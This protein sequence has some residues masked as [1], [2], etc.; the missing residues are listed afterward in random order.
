MIEK[1]KKRALRS[2]PIYVHVQWATIIQTGKK[3][4]NPYKL[5][6]METDDIF[7]MK[8]LASQI[9]SNFNKNE[10]GDKIKV[11]QA[12]K[13]APF[14]LEYKISYGE[15]FQ[16]I[17]TRQRGRLQTGP[18][19]LQKAYKQPSRISETKKDLVS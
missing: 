1:Q 4:G 8:H 6:Q 15:E 12:R 11:I 10:Q 17:N 14:I 3:T 13:D 19:H 18:L 9:G 5:K 7:Y 2:S 16:R